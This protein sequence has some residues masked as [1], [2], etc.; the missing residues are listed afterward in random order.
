MKK[1]GASVHSLGT[2]GIFPSKRVFLAGKEII[3]RREWQPTPVFLPG[4]SHGQSS[5][6]GTVRGVV[7]SRTQMK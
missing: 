3:W 4:K 6:A 7:K 2:V 5:L 1:P